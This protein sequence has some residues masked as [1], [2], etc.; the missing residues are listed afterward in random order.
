MLSPRE[1]TCLH[2]SYWTQQ[3]LWGYAVDTQHVFREWTTQWMN[4][5]KS[6]PATR[7]SVQRWQWKSSSSNYSLRDSTTQGKPTQE[8]PPSPVKSEE[9]KGGV[10]APHP[11]QEEKLGRRDSAGSSENPGSHVSGSERKGSPSGEQ[12]SLT[13]GDDEIYHLQASWL[14]LGSESNVSLMPSNPRNNWQQQNVYYKFH[15]A[16]ICSWRR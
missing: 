6:F 10:C 9:R 2:L 7:C 3:G 5:L 4:D 12:P 16:C 14:D 13:D 11:H 8:A 1:R 15:N